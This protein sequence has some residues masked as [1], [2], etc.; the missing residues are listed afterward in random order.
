[1][2]SDAYFVFAAAVPGDEG[3]QREHR[4]VETLRSLPGMGK[5]AAATVLAEASALL[6]ERDYYA[7]RAHAGSPV[8]KQNGK[9]R[10]V[11]MRYARNGRLHCALY[12]WARVA[13]ICDPA[14]KTYYVA[15]R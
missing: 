6:A 10:T 14:S 2:V 1:M 8:T 3:Q 13:V 4:D 5:V 11:V 12:Y 7:L 9:R 15:L